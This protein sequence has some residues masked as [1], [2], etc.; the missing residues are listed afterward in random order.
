MPGRERHPPPGAT[1]G[2]RQLAGRPRS[3]QTTAATAGP[4]EK[5]SGWL[6]LLPADF[7]PMGIDKPYVF[8][9]HFHLCFFC[10]YFS[11]HLPIYFLFVFFF[12]PHLLTCSRDAWAAS[13][14]AGS[15][16]SRW[17]FFGASDAISSAPARCLCPAAILGLP[18]AHGR[19][20][21][22]VQ[23]PGTGRTWPPLW[24]KHA[25]LRGR[26]R[27]TPCLDRKSTQLHRGLGK[28]RKPGLFL[29]PVAC[30]APLCATLVVATLPDEF[31]IP[32]WPSLSATSECS[33]SGH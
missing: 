26:Q 11:S 1:K 22:L 19:R 30:L 12:S 28:T 24:R 18:G 7:T 5:G 31:Q 14:G 10:F 20:G 6:C 27:V 3:R 33:H 13:P 21:A 8:I 9:F 25:V 2:T 32:S 16:F 17:V 29:C 4:S 23:S 15:A